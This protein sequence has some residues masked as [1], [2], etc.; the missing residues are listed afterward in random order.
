MVR[1]AVLATVSLELAVLLLLVGSTVVPE[2]VTEFVFVP[3]AFDATAT[4]M[5]TVVDVSTASEPVSEHAVALVQLQFVPVADTKVRP[6]GRVSFSATPVAA[7]GPLF[8]MTM[9]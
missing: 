8:V 5:L 6:V 1:F 3:V 9:S 2:T 7:D 4:V